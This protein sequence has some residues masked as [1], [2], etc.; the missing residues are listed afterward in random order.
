MGFKQKIPWW[1]KITAKLVLSRLPVGYG[2][3]QRLGLFR[4]GSMDDGRYAL[5]MFEAHVASAGLAGQLAGKTILELGPGDSVA[6]AVIA[7][8]YGA[9][10]ILVDV[11]KFATERLDVY[12]HLAAQLQSMGLH[13]PEIGGAKTLN[14]LLKACDARYL[15]AGLASL[16]QLPD[17]SVDF[18]F[19]QAVLEHIRKQEFLDTQQELARILK[20]GGVCSHQV[21]LRDHLGGGLNNLRFSDRVWESELFARS[22]FY[23][24]R[25]NFEQMIEMFRK[26]GFDVEI[27]E[28]RRWDEFP[29]DRRHLATKF[30]HL[31]D[32]VLTVSGFAI[33]LRHSTSAWK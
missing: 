8:A 6:S 26:V 10:M 2:F 19:S 20:R 4:L 18:I 32:E 5:G 28:V 30:R 3:W 17:A 15:T 22:G 14:E 9:R 13:P 29:I 23:T 33:L 11:G 24:N 16:R 1:G 27:V 12:Y 21:D 7:R 25:I 31:P